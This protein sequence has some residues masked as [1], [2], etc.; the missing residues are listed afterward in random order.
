MLAEINAGRH[1][2]AAGCLNQIRQPSRQW[3]FVPLVVPERWRGPWSPPREGLSQSRT[4][5]FSTDAK[6]SLNLL[7]ELCIA[8]PPIRPTSRHLEITTQAPS[9]AEIHRHA[10]AIDSSDHRGENWGSTRATLY[11]TFYNAHPADVAGYSTKSGGPIHH[12]SREEEPVVGSA[13]A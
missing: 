7:A 13:R 5:G 11:K 10:G 9:Q 8:Q 3:N 2:H 6:D 1:A 12:S 4:E